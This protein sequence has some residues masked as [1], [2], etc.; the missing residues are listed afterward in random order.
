M[1][2]NEEFWRAYDGLPFL[3]RL[4]VMFLAYIAFCFIGTFGLMGMM[5]TNPF[6]SRSANVRRRRG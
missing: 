2:A 4:P 6:A 1:A 5:L 3:V